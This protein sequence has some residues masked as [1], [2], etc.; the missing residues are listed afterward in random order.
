MNLG[1]GTI[2]PIAGTWPHFAALTTPGSHQSPGPSVC[3]TGWLNQQPRS[4]GETLPLGESPA[5]SGD[6]PQHPGPAG[7]TSGQ[8]FILLHKFPLTPQGRS[9]HTPALPELLLNA[10]P[11]STPLSGPPGTLTRQVCATSD[12]VELLGM[13]SSWDSPRTHPPGLSTLY[14]QELAHCLRASKGTTASRLTHP[15]FFFFHSFFLTALHGMWGLS[16]PTRDRTHTPCIGSAE[17]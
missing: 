1:R 8:L 13:H 12:C 16:S 7:D 14:H 15:F 9:P 17:P 3:L 10:A 6:Q 4:S 11:S 5:Y 2:Q